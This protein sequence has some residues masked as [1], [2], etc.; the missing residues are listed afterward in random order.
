MYALVM[1]PHFFSLLALFASIPGAA[2]QAPLYVDLR[3]VARYA[4]TTLPEAQV[5]L[6]DFVVNP[7]RYFPPAVKF[8]PVGP[9]ISKS[10]KRANSVYG[11]ELFKLPEDDGFGQKVLSLRAM[12]HS[13]GGKPEWFFR[14]FTV[15]VSPSVGVVETAQIRDIP[16]SDT[17]FEIQVSLSDRKA[18]LTDSRHGIRKVYP[19]GVGS[20]DYGVTQSSKGKTVL[21]T[22]SFFGAKIRRPTAMP[23]VN[24]PAYYYGMPFL[25]ITV[26]TGRLTGFAFHILQ[27]AQEA[28]GGTDFNYMLRAFDSHG[29][30]RTREKDLYELFAILRFQ[31]PDEIPLESRLALEEPNGVVD[32]PY[33]LDDSFHQRV[34][35]FGTAA[36]PRPGLDKHGLTQT[37]RLALAPPISELAPE[38]F[39]MDESGLTDIVPSEFAQKVG[40]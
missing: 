17:A 33:P 29:C 23:A 13:Q 25:G 14:E 34:K 24:F 2:A 35:N 38:V 21:M 26:K 37:E 39:T 16:V 22:P 18:L 40:P 8:A 5:V 6:T 4:P 19:L 36:K 9:G 7:G 12:I 1:R 30:F 28:P 20:F 10:K 11:V 32:H 27:H 31:G 15:T 3:D